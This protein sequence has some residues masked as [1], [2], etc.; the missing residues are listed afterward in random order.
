MKKTM[1]IGAVA[2]VAIVGFF[3]ISPIVTSKI[4]EDNF[5]TVTTNIAKEANIEL[6]DITYQSSLTGATAYTAFQPYGQ[7]QDSPIKIK[8]EISTLPFYTKTDGSSGLAAA[9][10]KSTLA[11][12]N[13]S[14][15]IQEKINTAFNN[16]PPGLLE[17][18]VDYN[19][20]Y[21]LTLTINP[22]EIMENQEPNQNSLKFSGLDGSFIVSENGEQV[23][24][25]AQFQSLVINSA[26][27]ATQLAGFETH[28]NQNKTSTG[29]WVGKSDLTIANINTQTPM[30]EFVINDIKAEA[31]AVDQ[32]QTLEY[33][34][35]FV[36]KEIV[37]PE[38]FP[39]AVNSMDYQININNIDA[40]AA[41][42]LIH[43]LQDM[44]R[45]LETGT[46]EEQQQ[47][48]QQ[49]GTQNSESFDQLLRA[50]PV[51]IQA[52]VIDTAQGPVNMD[53]N[54]NITGFAQHQ[55][56]S[57]L[58]TPAQL[59]QYVSGNL[60]AQSPLAL[61]LM[62][63]LAPQLEAYQQQGLLTVEGDTA[64]VNAVLK[65]SQLTINDQVM[66][67]QF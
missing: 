51:M 61:L 42:N 14:T 15:E 57:S 45:Q 56:V 43:A 46:P 11:D 27:N 36:I 24:G 4:M 23:T 39:L 17:T 18:V 19:G 28:M 1:V 47:I 33:L 48:A 2:M 49:F 32:T 65:D 25:T 52:L 16:Q 26:G 37:S 35:K 5:S 53:M 8:H 30:G 64:S 60:K 9:Y 13:F 67:M 55:T 63:P 44:Q 6:K 58:E 20:N 59:M 31:N 34:M 21:H 50:N 12:D 40:T 62:T 29:L 7:T 66:P 22:A 41:A 10:I 54:V 38:G 3:G